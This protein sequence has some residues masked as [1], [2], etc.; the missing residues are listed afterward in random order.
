MCVRIIHGVR[1]HVCVM[2]GAVWCSVLCL[3]PDDSCL[4]CGALPLPLPP[5]AAGIK[6]VLEYV[7]A[8]GYPVASSLLKSAFLES[9]YGFLLLT[10]LLVAGVAAS[11]ASQGLYGLLWG[12]GAITR[13]SKGKGKGK[14]T[15]APAEEQVS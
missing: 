2:I 3:S 5:P 1:L 10:L 13:P 12:L 7:N 15:P 11:I 14:S 8:A 9:R 6:P 4:T